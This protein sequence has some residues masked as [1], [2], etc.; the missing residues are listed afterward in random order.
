MSVYAIAALAIFVGCSERAKTEEEALPL[1]FR[2]KR[3]A[4]SSPQRCLN[5]HQ[6]Q[7]NDWVTSH[8]AKA[9]RPLDSEI[10]KDAFQSPIAAGEL[11][12]KAPQVEGNDLMMPLNPEGE[13]SPARG[14][15]A[16]HPL[17]QYLIE[18]EGG[19]LQAHSLAFDPEKKEW[20]DIFGDEDRQVGEWGHWTGQGMNWNSNC[21]WCHMTEFEKG[22]DMETDSY[23][24]KWTAQSVSCLQCHSQAIEHADAAEAGLEHVS[25]NPYGSENAELAMQNC[26]GCHSRREEL[27]GGQFVSGDNY[28]DHYSLALPIREGLYFADLKAQDEDYVYASLQLSPMGHAG[29]SCLDC[30]NPHSGGFVAPKE[31]N[32][33]CMQCHGTGK[34][35]SPL[36]NP[37]V[38]SRHSA[39][40]SGNSCIECHM[41][42]RTYMARDPRHDHGFTI[43]D[44]QLSLEMGIPNACSSCHSD[45]DDQWAAEQF[46]KWFS[47]PS[48]EARREHARMMKQAW[49]AST[50]FPLEAI[51]P[52][53]RENENPYRQATY[54]QLLANAGY[55]SDILKTLPDPTQSLEPIVR[56]AAAQLVANDSPSNPILSALL[57]DSVRG[58]RIAA[59]DSFLRTDPN[60]PMDLSEWQARL[61]ANSDRPQTRL[62]LA[63]QAIE[64]GDPQSAFEHMKVA[65]SFDSV[66]SAV[67]YQGA[68]ILASGGYLEMAH[69]FLGTAPQE[70]TADGWIDYAEGL[71]WA[72][73]QNLSRSLES[74]RSAVSK[75][76]SQ[77]RWWYNLVAAQLR[78][79]DT[80]AADESLREAL[81]LHPNSNAL[82]SLLQPN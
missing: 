8:H 54:L 10:D 78:I 64:Q 40:S 47:G 65:A 37:T 55:S 19:R 82:L 16:Y 12:Q 23:A 66:N 53:Y 35:D 11:E 3:A 33:L 59:V 30:H 62:Q 68:I 14:V 67:Y 56:E 76:P 2:P 34:L 20:F 22:Y 58:V 39:G 81:S 61:E 5:C 27:T 1:T 7:H 24:S 50:P 73:R 44:P 51:L 43:P 26:A 49:D 72:E 6:Q 63:S 69:I 60:K 46:D 32:T 79:G 36:I 42:T 31:N 21:A 41:P 18:S 38:H 80:Q 4:A 75:D 48:V 9:N 71:L 52:A 13:M 77:D 74:L 45:Q 17:R 57:E 29:V 25:A 15:L 28:H 70:A